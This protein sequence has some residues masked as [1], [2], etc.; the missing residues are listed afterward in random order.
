VKVITAIMPLT[1]CLEVP[2]SNL[3]LSIDYPDLCFFV[4][5]PKSFRLEI[6][7]DPFLA[8]PFRDSL[9]I[10]ISSSQSRINKPCI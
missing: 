7:Y 5:F 4:V 2:F 6:G 9:N 3:D 1:F 8:N 10:I